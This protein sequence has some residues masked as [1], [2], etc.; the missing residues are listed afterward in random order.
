VGGGDGGFVRIAHGT[1]VPGHG[2]G[3]QGWYLRVAGEVGIP[4]WMCAGGKGGKVKW[5]CFQ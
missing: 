2:G 3:W 5:G 1:I 4:L